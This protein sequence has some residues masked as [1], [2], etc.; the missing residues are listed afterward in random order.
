[1]ITLHAAQGAASTPWAWI[2]AASA[3]AYLVKLAGYLLPQSFLQR[4]VAL[5]LAALVT[6]GLLAS[7]TVLNT[8]T[9]GRELTLDARI[10]A[11]GVAVVALRMRA[12][13]LLVVVLGAASVALARALGWG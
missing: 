9:S 3:L 13:F 10:L 1:M 7:L 12:P 5:H 8:L 6:V 11:L 2:L 4:P